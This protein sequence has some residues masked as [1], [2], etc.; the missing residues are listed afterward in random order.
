MATIQNKLIF[1]TG[2]LLLISFG[3]EKKYSSDSFLFEP[4]VTY[5]QLIEEGWNYFQAGDYDTSIESFIMASERDATQP[6]VYLGLGWGYARNIELTKSVSNF[7]KANSFA[8]FDPVNETR[9]LAESF[10]GLSLVSLASGNYAN[11]IDYAD[12]TL[13]L[14][15]E[16]SFS[17]DAAVNAFSLKLSQAESY[18]YLENIQA[19]FN[20][21]NELGANINNVT[22]T[23]SYGIVFHTTNTLLTGEMEV[24]LDNVHQLISVTSAQRESINYEIISIEEGTNKFMMSGNPI[25]ASGDSISVSYYFTIDYADFLNKLLSKI[26]NF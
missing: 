15:A 19:C 2:I 7:Q 22:D 20:I 5:D 9:I 26:I 11:C 4:P 14:A 13:S 3:C 17:K 12:Q 16:F 6:E 24:N 23:T 25:V 8:F 10:A 21:I 18:Y 1:I